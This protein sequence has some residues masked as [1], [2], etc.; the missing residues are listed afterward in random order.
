L[1]LVHFESG[2]LPNAR[3]ICNSHHTR[4]LFCQDDHAAGVPLTSSLTAPEMKL[5][6]CLTNRNCRRKCESRVYPEFLSREAKPHAGRN[7]GQVGHEQRTPLH[8]SAQ[9][10][11][12]SESRLN[13]PGEYRNGALRQSCMWQGYYRLRLQLHI[14]PGRGV[15]SANRMY[16]PEALYQGFRLTGLH[17][18]RRCYVMH[19]RDEGKR[20]RNADAAC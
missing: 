18:Q 15:W 12:S 8:C 3:S 10:T 17:G 20:A 14:P 9:V 2:Q 6:C 7:R 13:T 5:C 1:L 4:P 11:A 19:H 16:D